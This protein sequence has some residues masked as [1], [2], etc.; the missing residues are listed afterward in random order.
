MAMGQTPTTQFKTMNIRNFIQNLL[1]PKPK[2]PRFHGGK[3]IPSHKALSSEKPSQEMPLI[4][5]YYLSLQARDG[6]LF[7]AQVKVGERVKRGQVLLRPSNQRDAPVH[8]PTSGIITAITLHPNMHESN[9]SALHLVLESDGLDESLPPQSALDYEQESREVLLERVWEA[10]IVGMGGAGFPSARKLNAQA[11]T[12]V[13]NAAECEPYIT[14]DDVQIQEHAP[15]IIKGAQ[16]AAHITGAERIIFGIEDDK[17][18]AIKALQSALTQVSD[19]RLSL[20]VIPTVYPSGNTRQLFELLLDIRVPANHHATDYGLI[21]HNTATLKALYDAIILGLPLTERYTAVTGEGVHNP[22]VVRAR[23]GTPLSALAQAA[24]GIK[25]NSRTII[26]GPMMGYELQNL[27]AGLQKTGNCLLALPQTPE[28]DESPCIRCAECAEHCPMELLPQ[29]LL[30]Y[31]RS[32]D[33]KHLEEYRLFDCIECG[34]CAAVC[35]SNIPLV[36]HYRH[37]KANIRQAKQKLEAAQHAKKRHEARLERLERERIER[38]AKMAA[39]EAGLLQ[40]PPPPTPVVVRPQSALPTAEMAS[41]SMAPSLSA[42]QP[43][44]FDPTQSHSASDAQMQAIAAAKARAAERAAA[45]KAKTSDANQSA[46]PSTEVVSA[47]IA[48]TEPAPTEDKLAAAK[49]RAAER[50]AARKAKANDSH[51]SALPSAEVVS[52]EIAPTEPAP[53]EDKLAAA[54][55]RAAERAAARKAK[56]NNPTESS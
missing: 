48:P 45:R 24:D 2:A 38:E 6:E 32:D 8:A 14:C 4:P 22:C 20:Q 37:S 30:W 5:C 42:A 44:T 47:E 9:Q 1:A 31:S 16:I 50:A 28:A 43:P 33:H 49:A 39:R 26:G 21:C 34:L 15:E 11:K 41:P 51:Q 53:T 18:L 35:P 56:T 46:L 17:P 19:T 7:L 27:N 25:P 29:Q 52:A 55:A 13:V 10:G 40:S 54:K 36:Q 3:H 23:I 12:L